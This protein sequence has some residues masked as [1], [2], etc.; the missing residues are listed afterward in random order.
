MK[1]KLAAA[2]LGYELGVERLLGH[3]AILIVKNKSVFLYSKEKRLEEFFTAAQVLRVGK[4]EADEFFSL[5][6]N[7]AK[8][9]YR[10]RQV[11]F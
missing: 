10:V 6:I 3:G 8:S 2:F 9:G 5:V 4:E 1:E 7:V 11:I